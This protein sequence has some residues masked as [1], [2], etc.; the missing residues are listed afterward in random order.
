M[1][2]K[3]SREHELF[4]NLSEMFFYLW[5]EYGISVGVRSGGVCSMVQFQKK[6]VL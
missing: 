6:Q 1:S 2:E 5:E 4:V 3:S